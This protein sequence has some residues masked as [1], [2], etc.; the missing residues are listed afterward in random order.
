MRMDKCTIIYYVNWLR[1]ELDHPCVLEAGLNNK[2]RLSATVEAKMSHAF[3]IAC[4]GKG[5]I[6]HRLG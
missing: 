4:Q 1:S 6:A 2:T 3:N 5:T